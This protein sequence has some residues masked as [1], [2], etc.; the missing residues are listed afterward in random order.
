MKQSTANINDE[1]ATLEKY[2]SDIINQIDTLNLSKK[3]HKIA[4]SYLKKG[5]QLADNIYE[6]PVKFKKFTNSID[7][8]NTTE[9]IMQV[10]TEI[11]KS[12]FIA[13]EGKDA[14]ENLN[15]FCEIFKNQK[16]Q[17]KLKECDEET[18]KV[19]QK[20]VEVLSSK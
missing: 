9:D 20:M 19:L 1:N 2:R 16:A 6:D 18:R 5:E 7:Q 17:E 10:L 8:A 3:D 15:K 4:M 14:I 11:F 12:E 13:N